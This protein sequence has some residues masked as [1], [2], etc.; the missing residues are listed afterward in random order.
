M[1]EALEGG[2]AVPAVSGPSGAL[3]WGVFL[4]RPALQGKHLHL[5]LV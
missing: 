3:P 1:G 2:C 5:A 4:T